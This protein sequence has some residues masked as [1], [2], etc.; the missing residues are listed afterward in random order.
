MH[1]LSRTYTGL[2]SLAVCRS[3]L[4]ARDLAGP[5]SS[6]RKGDGDG[7][8]IAG[9]EVLDG[10]LYAIGGKDEK[11]NKLRT[12]ERYDVRS[13]SW[14]SVA[15]MM[16]KRWGAGVASLESRCASRLHE[17]VED[18]SCGVVSCGGGG[19][20]FGGEEEEV[21]FVAGASMHGD[22]VQPVMVLG[23]LCRCE[24]WPLRRA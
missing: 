19:A 17:A 11:G 20:M 18:A 8:G 9:V 7:C 2:H 3:Q 23:R 10:M 15:S 5:W 13:N 21:Q 12:V 1:V 6:E 14:S 4:G 16:T 22:E 24:V